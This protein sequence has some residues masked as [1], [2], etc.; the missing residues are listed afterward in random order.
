MTRMQPLLL[1]WYA[2][3]SISWSPSMQVPHTQRQSLAVA[4]SSPGAAA[5]TVSVGTAIR[6]APQSQCQ[7]ASFQALPS[8]RS[9]VARGTHWR[10]LFLAQS[11]H[12]GRERREL[13]AW[14][15]HLSRA[16][17][18][19][20]FPCRRLLL[21]SHAASTTPSPSPSRGQSLHGAGGGHFQSL[22]CQLSCRRACRMPPALASIC[23]ELAR[24]PNPDVAGTGSWEWETPSEHANS[25]HAQQWA[26]S[27][28]V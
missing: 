14:V 16:A 15:M 4:H 1:P 7:S 6:R 25:L 12:G 9:L 21:R 8:V 18:R 13:S 19:P 27:D 10:Y 24:A 26:L 20:P 2:R 22:D 3:R 5:S 28:A 17:C 11:L 23:V